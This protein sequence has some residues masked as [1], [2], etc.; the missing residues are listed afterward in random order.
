MTCMCWQYVTLMTAAS[1]VGDVQL[2][3]D[4]FADMERAGVQHTPASIGAFV[5]AAKRARAFYLV[6][7]AWQVAQRH[8]VPLDDALVR[9]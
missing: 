6:P 3:E 9:P 1:R 2:L 7:R 4:L 5:H 8:N